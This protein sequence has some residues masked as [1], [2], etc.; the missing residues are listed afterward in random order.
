MSGNFFATIVRII[1]VWES[2]VFSSCK[3]LQKL[4]FWKKYKKYFP[5]KTVFLVITRAFLINLEKFLVGQVT[6]S[7]KQMQKG[8]VVALFFA[9]VK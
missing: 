8:V 4:A 9:K 1:S 6:N 5:W 2:Q 3:R 7:S